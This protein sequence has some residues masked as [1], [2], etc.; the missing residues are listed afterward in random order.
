MKYRLFYSYDTC[1]NDYQESGTGR[2]DFRADS[3][4]KATKKVSAILNS[5]KREFVTK[6]RMTF[7]SITVEDVVQVLNV[8][9]QELEWHPSD[10]Y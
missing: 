8:D 9:T 7:G 1:R 3:P 6:R 4:K 5:L 2:R 10:F